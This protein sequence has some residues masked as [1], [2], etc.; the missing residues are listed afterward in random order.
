MD[1]YVDPNA[2]TS[3]APPALTR[4]VAIPAALPL[5]PAP[6]LP[7]APDDVLTRL[8]AQPAAE[9]AVR[10]RLRAARIDNILVGA[11]FL[12]LCLLAH[13]RVLTIGHLAV[14]GLLTVVYHYVFEV[15]G[16]QT[17]GKRRY[18]IQVVRA[19]GGPADGR[20]IAIRSILRLVD[21]LPV[22]YASGLVSMVRTGP[23]RRQRIGDVAAGTV[24]VA[25]DGRAAGR[26]T[27]GWWLPVATLVAVG[28]SVMTIAAASQTGA[29]PAT[30]QLPAPSAVG[31]SR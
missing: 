3:V 15:R 19:D 13:W 29:H 1:S 31:V 10:W 28:L 17:P 24:V 21:Q 11:V 8:G 22:Y 23:A 30:A 26:G 6:A 12:A 4:A 25:V 20:A 18:G 7:A 16:G 14:F 27:P 9:A 5:A 2:P